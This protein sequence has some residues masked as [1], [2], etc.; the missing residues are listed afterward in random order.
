MWR[1]FFAVLL[2]MSCILFTNFSAEAA[3]KVV[4]VLPLENVS[5][6]SKENISDIM[7]EQLIDVIH[8]S[9]QYTVIETTQMAAVL[10]QQGFENLVSS[11]AIDFG[12]KTGSDY[13]VVGKVILAQTTDNI[14]GI[15]G[16]FGGLTK[17]G[18]GE[19]DSAEAGLG[20]LG[21]IA[22]LNSVKGKVEL[23]VRF[24][25]NKSG[26]IVF[27]KTFSGEQVGKDSRTAL[28]SACQEAS[29]NF[30]KELQ[31][32]N[33]FAARIADIDGENIYIDQGLSSGLQPGETLMIVRELEPIIVN[34]KAVGMKT[35]SICTAKVIQVD[36]E[37]AICRA[38]GNNYLLQKGDIV[39]RY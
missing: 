14:S 10:R 17:A 25:D 22:N 3:K 16:I 12:N 31:I 13:S 21:R 2:L 20:L 23:Q 15:L 4:A 34:G 30:L 18:S 19:V 6:Y 7:T 37:F 1:K 38:D 33:P 32:A 29:Q 27:A 9:G 8:N 26:E 24:V 5:G 39:K 11:E 36:S 35:I 28:I